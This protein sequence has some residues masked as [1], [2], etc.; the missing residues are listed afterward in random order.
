MA[1]T[2]LSALTELAATPAVGDELYIRDISELAADESK[3]ITI[4]N[5]MEFAAADTI[6][7]T[8]KT[9]DVNGIG[10]SITNIENADIAV[11]AAIAYSKLAALTDGNILV[12]N[13]SNVAV[14]VNP[15]GDVDISNAGDFSIAAGVIVDDDVS[16]T[17]E[18]AV[19]KLADGAARQLLQTD[20]GGTGVEWA[21]NIDIPGTLDVTGAAVLDSTLTVAGDVG[22][23]TTSPNA[24]L[25]LEGSPPGSVGGFQSGIFHVTNSSSTEFQNS[26]V[27]GHNLFN[28]NTQLWYLGSTSGSNN[29]VAFINRQ[30]ANMFF[31]TN[32]AERVTILA[33][34][35]VGINDTGPDFQFDV[36]GSIGLDGTISIFEQVAADPDVATRGQVWVKTATPNELFFTNDDGLDGQVVLPA[37]TITFTNKTFDANGTGNSITNIENADVAAAA[38]IAFSKL[39]ALTDGNILVGNGSNVVVSVNPSGDVDVSNAGVFSITA[40]VIVDADVKS[41]AA[42]SGSKL[43]AAGLTNSGAVELA[44]TGETT[45]GTDATRALTPDGLAGSDVM[46]GRTV[47]VVAFDFGTDVTTGDGKFYFLIDERLAGMNIVSVRAKNITAGVTGQQ[48]VQL[49]NVTA[50]ADILSTKLVTATTATL[51]DGNAVIDAAQD[52]LTLDDLIAVDVDTIHSGTAPKGLIIIIGTRLP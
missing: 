39:A 13:G 49:R 45:T 47:Q 30:N 3:R 2:K 9:F 11:A 38:A 12:G 52:D 18:I 48:D 17:A 5:L 20:S 27:T 26:V 35:K 16:A 36:G 19:S 46:G 32:N 33:D 43:Q 8:N 24:P 15:S 21:S 14:S 10:N 37:N 50:A 44:T 7:F 25:E 29:V 23:G 28:T 40:D 1:D 6:T 31:S 4:A 42:I 41:D 34:G 22:I 51:D